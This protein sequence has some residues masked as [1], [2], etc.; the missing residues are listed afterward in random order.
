MRRIGILLAV[1]LAVTTACAGTST[2]AGARS[3]GSAASSPGPATHFTD[4]PNF[5]NTVSK[6]GVANG[7]VKLPLHQAWSR[8]LDGPVWSEPV[9]GDGVLITA[10]EHNA[11]YGL[12]PRTGKVLWEQ[13]LAIPEPGSSQPCGDIDPIGITGSPAYDPATGSVFVVD[14]SPSGHHTIWALSAKTGQ[15]RWHRSGDPDKARD[16]N[17]EQQRA[18]LVVVD[19][20]VIVT[21]GAHAGDCGNYVGYAMSVATNGKGRTPYYAV[22][23]ARQ[24][25][26]WGPAGPVEAYDGNVLTPTANGSN[27]TGGTWDHSDGVIELSPRTMHYVRGWAPSNWEEGDAD[28]LSLGSTSPVQVAGDYVVGGKRGEVWLLKPTLGGVGGELDTL[29]GDG[30]C[31]AFGGI[32]AVGNTAIIP[33]KNFSKPHSVLAVTVSNGKL[34]TKWTASGMYGAPVIAGQRVF[35]ADLD[36]GDLEVLS[37]KNGHVITSIPVGSL[38]TFPSE[39]VD[40]NH[41]FVPTLSGITAIRGS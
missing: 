25:G 6:S 22:P 10:T 2:A 28:D 7:G 29:G 24:A 37:L 41:V 23:N 12:D 30:F 21:Y 16:M 36:S 31:N 20:R 8:K 11:V 15:R 40:G 18:A 3:A 34:H 35:V 27:R 38:A 19:H 33:C 13:K 26:M 1:P 5:H 39:V 14:T 4:W 17:A 32:A 9:I